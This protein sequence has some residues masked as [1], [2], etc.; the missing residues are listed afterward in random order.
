MLHVTPM[1]VH[2][3]K[4]WVE[5][6]SDRCVTCEFMSSEHELKACRPGEKVLAERYVICSDDC[7]LEDMWGAWVTVCSHIEVTVDSPVIDVKSTSFNIVTSAWC[8]CYYCDCQCCDSWE[9]A[10]APQP[11]RI[12]VTALW[13]LMLLI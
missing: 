7:S 13:M 2:K 12:D 6:L 5:V 1:W 3:F 10:G 11:C 4:A 9:G 8:C